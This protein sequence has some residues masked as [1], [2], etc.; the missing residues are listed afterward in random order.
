[1]TRDRMRALK[2]SNDMVD[3]VSQLVYLHLRF[4]TYEMGWTD[5]A[6]R[7]FVRD[8]GPLLS[9]LLALTRSDCTTRN[10]RKA[11]ALARRIDDLEARI[12][13]LAE[14]EELASI[15]PDLDGRQVM[16]HL[17][18]PAGPAVGQALSHLL[19]LRLDR[20]PMTTAEAYRELDLW[21]AEQPDLHADRDA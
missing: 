3:D 2:F 16:D 6:V 5:S 15:R 13:V 7:R 20:G 18:V 19:E 1:M 12:A 21:F 9:E 14:Q 11:D 4:H 10:Q 17:G 8:A